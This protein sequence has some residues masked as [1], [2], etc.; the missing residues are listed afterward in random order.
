MES[1]ELNYKLPLYTSLQH[2]IEQYHKK[3]K[4]HILKSGNL[5]ESLLV[6]SP[7]KELKYVALL[8]PQV[9]GVELHKFPR[10][11]AI[12]IEGDNLWFCDEIILG[13][14]KNTLNITNPAE[15]VSRRVV[16]F[17]YS[18][19]ASS[20]KIDRAI[21]RN[22]IMKVTLNSHFAK[23]IRKKVKVEQVS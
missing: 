18:T 8:K 3:V 1:H 14:G 2:G 4:I 12:V 22:E 19:T 23:P 6:P 16:Q 5:K 7:K 17:N 15:L 13:E 21:A 20:G 10:E 11:H 9:K